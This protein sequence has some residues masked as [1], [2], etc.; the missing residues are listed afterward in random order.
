MIVCL[1]VLYMAD[2]SHSIAHISAASTW[3]VSS[4]A[5][6]IPVSCCGI[7]IELKEKIFFIAE[8]S[9]E[10]SACENT[11]RAVRVCTNID[12]WPRA[13]VNL[14]TWFKAEKTSPCGFGVCFLL[15]EGMT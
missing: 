15:R 12:D 2:E 11:L 10:V 1:H 5:A 6:V 13:Q 14:S 7:P 4:S 9:I 3:L 8:S